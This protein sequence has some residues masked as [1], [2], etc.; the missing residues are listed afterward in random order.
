MNLEVK[1][2]YLAV[3]SQGRQ[4]AQKLQALLEGGDLYTTAKLQTEDTLVLEGGVKAYMA[5]LFESYDYIICIMATGIVVRSIAP[6]VNNKLLDP[7][8]I[9]LDER[10]QNVISLLS[11]HMGGGNE[12][13]K[14]ISQL[15]KAHPVITTATDVNGKAALDN[16]AKHLN[17]YIPNFRD[18]V[19]DIN[20]RLVQNEAV[21][22]YIDGDYEVDERGFIKIQS[23]LQP[24]VLEKQLKTFSAV[25]YIT[26]K[27]KLSFQHPNL[28]KVVPRDLTL[29]M[30]C[31]K[32][33]EVGHMLTSFKAY[34]AQHD[35]DE[36][37]ICKVGSI[38]LKKDEV[39]M[40]AL[41]SYLE[42]PFEVF[43]KEEI[44]KVEA[45]FPKSEFVKKNVGVYSVA[46]PVAY[47]MSHK[48]LMINREKYEGITFALGKKGE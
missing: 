14:R 46:E 23:E 18:T 8:V 12:M 44:I 25:V 21:G 22:L 33:T 26:Q 11:G 45:L 42:V 10:A 7:A 41:A 15:L 3:T 32:H 28:I 29:G 20:Y 16:I 1:I 6:Y 30:G 2:A 4:L 27:Q 35:L 37:A 31:K 13:T 24:A 36:H 17:A 34:M 47:L 38:E 40:Q 39:A 48:T 9:V 43:T 19:K 5:T